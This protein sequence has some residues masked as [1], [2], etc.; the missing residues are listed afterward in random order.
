MHS[1]YITQVHKIYSNL[2]TSSVSIIGYGILSHPS[3][4]SLIN[5]LKETK[6]GVVIVDE[7]H[8]LKN[9]KAAR[10]KALVQIIQQAKRAVL[11]TGTPALAR[12][13]EVI[14]MQAF[15]QCH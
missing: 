15:H 14:Q 3:S 13:E 7:S 9:R 10:T 11:L 1:N 4:R 8:Y 5:C 6:F 2:K 12:P